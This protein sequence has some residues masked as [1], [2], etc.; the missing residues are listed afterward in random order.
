MKFSE[1]EQKILDLLEEQGHVDNTELSHYLQCSTVT[2]RTMMRSLEK[3]GLLI[4]THGGARSL[5]NHLTLTVPAGNIFKDSES[6]MKIAERAYQYISDRDTIIIDESSNSYYLAQVIKKYANKYLIVITNS[7]AVAAE[8]SEC[9]S[10]DVISI[11]GMLTKNPP[12]FVGDFAINTLKNFKAVKAF[13]GVHGIDPE[14]GITSIGNEQMMI[15]KLIFEITQQV[16]VLACSNKFRTGYLLV[17]AKLEQIHKI[18]TDT[19]IN[20]DH[21]KQICQKV[22]LDLV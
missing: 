7:L 1:K 17:S 14:I 20:Q 22:N 8:L 5:D 19:D 16:Y 10:V 6:K 13:I 4:R 15:K 2:I 12:A 11:G 9:D 3:Q 18:I 21:Y